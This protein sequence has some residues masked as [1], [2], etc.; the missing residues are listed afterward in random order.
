[1]N[2]IIYFE[3]C[4]LII[5]ALIVLSMHQRNMIKGRVNRWFVMLMSMALMATITDIA[6]MELE[7]YSSGAI[8]AKYILNALCLWSTS[9]IS[10]M[11]CGYLFAQTGIWYKLN[12]NKVKKR[13]FYAPVFI[14]TCFVLIINIFTRW[15]FDINASG[16]YERGP[17]VLMLYGLSLVYVAI[18]LSV[19][20]KFRKL[21]TYRKVA[22]I[23]LLLFSSIIGTFIQ[24]FFPDVIIQMF[25]TALACLILFIEVQAPEERI[26]AETGL[27]SFNAYV[28]DVK[29]LFEIE[30]PFNVTIA[31]I[32][33]YDALIEMLGYL[34]ASSIMEQIAKKLVA[35]TDGLK[36]DADH[37]YL[38][39]GRFAVI[40]DDRYMDRQFEVAQGINAIVHEEY[41]VNDTKFVVLCNVCTVLCPDDIDDPN[42]LIAFDDRVYQEAYSGEL[43]YAEK[44]FDKRAFE[45]NRDFTKILDR[46]FDDDS[47]YLEYQPV[48]DYEAGRFSSVEAFLRLNDPDYGY[49][50]PDKVIAEAEKGELIHAITVY[51]VEEVCRFVSSSDFLLLGLDYVEINLSP[52][53]CMWADLITVLLATLRSYNVQPKYICFNI[54]DVDDSEVYKQMKANLEALSQIGFKLI[55]DDFG[56]G[57]FEIERIAQTP[58]KSIKLDKQFVKNGLEAQNLC[59]LKG[60]IRMIHDLD[61]ETA[62]VGIEDE[63]MLNKLTDLGCRYIQGYYYCKTLSRQDLIKF[64]LL[65]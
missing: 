11:L 52:M 41:T 38:G 29:K 4:A 40:L 20:I 61:I 44:L 17:I 14:N 19:V 46:A 33:N 32:T 34:S 55:L 56:A 62:A 64:L 58:L 54:T 35:Y 48:Y 47:F 36:I 22:S 7:F 53:Q 16:F 24:L 15:Y 49:I 10:V 39:N 13:I 27:S 12:N 45:F 65:D 42:F 8:I 43:R 23:I 51:V 26:H 3:Y 28:L 25:C 6:A 18:G 37:Y 21:Y 9:T 5:E 50:A 30:T 57:V 31:A 60:T 1:M 2:K 59:V 63:D